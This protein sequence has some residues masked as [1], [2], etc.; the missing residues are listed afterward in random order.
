MIDFN[1]IADGS[2][3]ICPSSIKKELIKNKSV[4]NTIKDIKFMSKEELISGFYFSYDSIY[5]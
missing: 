4:L 3:V 1:K 2:I 5:V